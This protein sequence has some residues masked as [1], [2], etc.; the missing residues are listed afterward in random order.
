MLVTF[1]QH[2]NITMSLLKNELVLQTWYSHCVPVNYRDHPRSFEC[3]H[4]YH[5]RYMYCLIALDAKVFMIYDPH[6]ISK[7]FL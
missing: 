6:S 1:H 2:H 4:V 3:C 7:C 5:N